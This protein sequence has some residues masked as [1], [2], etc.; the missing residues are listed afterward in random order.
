MQVRP[1]VGDSDF[2]CDELGHHYRGK[3]SVRPTPNPNFR[4][5]DATLFDEAG[6]PLLTFS[7]VLR[8]T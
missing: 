3:L 6:Y 2:Q 1:A 8:V 7:T 5:V 4:R